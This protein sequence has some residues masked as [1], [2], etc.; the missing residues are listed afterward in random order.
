MRQEKPMFR[1]YNYVA[2]LEHHVFLKVHTIP[3]D[4][5]QYVRSGQPILRGQDVVEV[6]L[7]E[8]PWVRGRGGH[9]RSPNQFGRRHRRCFSDVISVR[10]GKLCR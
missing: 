3:T 7:F 2:V 9:A 10:I 5:S 8:G 1:M 6:F 4:V